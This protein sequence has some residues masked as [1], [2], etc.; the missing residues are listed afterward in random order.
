MVFF[1]QN[2]CVLIVQQNI[3]P[4]QLQMVETVVGYRLQPVGSTEYSQEVGS[5]ENSPVHV[6]LQY[7]SLAGYKGGRSSFVTTKL[8]I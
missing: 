6:I 1:V 7:L 3:V 5:T 8:T 2:F 4:Q